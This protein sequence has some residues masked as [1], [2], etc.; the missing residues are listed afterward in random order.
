M[1]RRSRCGGDKPDPRD[2][3]YALGVIWYQLLTGDLTSP[4]RPAGGGWMTFGNAG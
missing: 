3:V 1:P 4:L 2:D